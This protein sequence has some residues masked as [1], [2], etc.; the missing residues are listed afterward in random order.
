MVDMIGAQTCPPPNKRLYIFATFRSYNFARLR[1]STFKLGN[2]TNFKALFPVVSK[3]FSNWS[4]L[5]VEKTVEG[6]KNHH[7]SQGLN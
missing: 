1:R 2:F 6:Q 5:K 7:V 4:M 3:D